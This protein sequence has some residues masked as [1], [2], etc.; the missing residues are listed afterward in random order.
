MI[1]IQRDLPPFGHVG[2]IVDDIDANVEVYR[3]LLG[4]DN[5]TVYDFMPDKAWAYKKK[6]V[7]CKLRI[8]MGVLKDGVK[9]ELIQPLSDNTPHANFLKEKGQG[10]HHIAFY[11]K[12]YEDWLDFYE[13]QG[14]KIVFEAETE[15][16]LFGYRRSFYAK[17]KDMVG[18]IEITEI[19]RKRT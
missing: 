18:I 9:I 13:K 11:T 17:L 2:Y 5:F 16:D 15:D 4:I 12:E 8:A 7:G 1:D 3:Q 19:A 14:A 6:I 10:L